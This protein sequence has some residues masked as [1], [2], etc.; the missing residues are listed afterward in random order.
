MPHNCKQKARNKT[1]E[2]RAAP[3]LLFYSGYSLK[4][5]CNKTISHPKLSQI[6]A[7]RA[8][9]RSLSSVFRTY[10]THVIVALSSPFTPESRFHVSLKLKLPH[11]HFTACGSRGVYRVKS[12]R[13]YHQPL[14]AP[15][16]HTSCS[17]LPPPTTC[18]PN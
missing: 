5:I 1:R 7:C 14:E 3:G 16:P 9:K 18:K 4:R 12:H 2:I 17:V 11:L 8:T 13:C 10:W 15:F 6:M